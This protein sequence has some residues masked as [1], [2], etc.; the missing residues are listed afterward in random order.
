MVLGQVLGQPCAAAVQEA[1]NQ[2]ERPGILLTSSRWQLQEGK[3][4]KGMEEKKA[5]VM[6]KVMLKFETSNKRFYLI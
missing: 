1:G 2:Q 6:F 4:E 3:K 5:A